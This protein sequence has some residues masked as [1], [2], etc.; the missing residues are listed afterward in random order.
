MKALPE[1]TQLGTLEDEDLAGEL[2]PRVCGVCLATTSALVRTGALT[3]MGRL[4]K[5]VDQDEAIKML[6]T[7]Q[8]VSSS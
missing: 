4:V 6:A 1:L 3:A 2:L 5:H 7:C 8:Q